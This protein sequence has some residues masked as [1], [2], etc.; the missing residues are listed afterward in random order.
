[1]EICLY[2]YRISVYIVAKC[3]NNVAKHNLPSLNKTIAFNLTVKRLLW[4]I[5]V[6]FNANLQPTK[7]FVGKYNFIL[8]RRMTTKFLVT[9][10]IT[11]NAVL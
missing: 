2:F 3:K 9:V 5:A 4:R 6:D 8:D 7:M 1:L 11:T 10:D